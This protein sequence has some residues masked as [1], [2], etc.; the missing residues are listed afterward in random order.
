MSAAAAVEVLWG[1]G[2]VEQ[3]FPSQSGNTVVS[4]LERSTGL[5]SQLPFRI[6]CATV[7]VALFVGGVE[8]VSSRSPTGRLR[9]RSHLEVLWQQGIKRGI[10]AAKRKEGCQPGSRPSLLL[11]LHTLAQNYP[12][13]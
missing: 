3:H 7:L 8:Q 13:T 6:S 1:T 11:L 10:S 4:P 9:R 5:V 12:G 2:A